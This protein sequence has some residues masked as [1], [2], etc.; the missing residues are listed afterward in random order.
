M[1]CWVSRDA[2]RE[3]TKLWVSLYFKTHPCQVICAHTISI[4]SLDVHLNLFD[5]DEFHL[6]V[7]ILQVLRDVARCIL[8]CILQTLEEPAKIFKLGLIKLD[9]ASIREATSHCALGLHMRKAVAPPPFPALIRIGV[10]KLVSGWTFSFKYQAVGSEC[11]ACLEAPQGAS[12]IPN[13]A[14][15]KLGRQ[16]I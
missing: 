4:D 16:S 8:T 3:Q 2:K 7:N 5:A 11:A 13:N 12:P 15:K 1:F 6:A 9:A 10:K 14:I